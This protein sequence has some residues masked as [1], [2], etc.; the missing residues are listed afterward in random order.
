MIPRREDVD[1]A[2][3][4]RSIACAASSGRLFFHLGPEWVRGPP[5]LALIIGSTWAGSLF[6][7]GT[8]GRRCPGRLPLQ[9]A[10]F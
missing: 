5:L 8:R 3:P 1:P 9:R 6:F 10:G 2:K 7:S 4:L